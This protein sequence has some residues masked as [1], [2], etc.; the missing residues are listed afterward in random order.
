MDLSRA[1]LVSFV[2]TVETSSDGH[3][4]WGPSDAEW[5]TRLALQEVGESASPE[6]FVEVRARLAWQRISDRCPELD[7]ALK[8]HYFKPLLG[9]LVVVFAF[10]LGVVTDQVGESKQ[11]NLLALPFAA[12]IL[13]NLAMYGWLL[14]VSPVLR[15][16]RVRK[17]QPSWLERLLSGLPADRERSS[18]KAGKTALRLRCLRDWG[19]CCGALTSLSLA[20]VWHVAALM[21]VLGLIASIYARG[22]YIEYRVGWES[23]ILDAADVQVILSALLGS[24]PLTFGLAVPDLAAV[25]QMRFSAGGGLATARPWLHVMAFLAVCVVVLPRLVLALWCHFRIRWIEHRFPIDL[26]DLYFQKLIAAYSRQ[27]VEIVAIPFAKVLTA[28]TGIKLNQI[29]AEVFGPKSTFKIGKTIP[30]GGEDDA[31]A[32]LNGASGVIRLALFDLTATPEVEHHGAF[33]KAL[34][35]SST[36]PV[37]AL[38]DAGEFIARFGLSGERIRQRKQLW[39]TFLSEQGIGCVIGDLTNEEAHEIRN[40]LAALV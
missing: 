39:E 35:E 20:R 1:K 17:V 24:L 38:V 30:L 4:V 5:A 23:T 32:A 36:R 34:R 12:I 19:R 40:A 6:R 27:P 33:L 2:K 28:T 7:K 25:E 16:F 31:R 11:V 9:W 37:I 21:L 10:F 22:L 14:V 26:T 8:R 13:W 15:L 3:N 18:A 29:A